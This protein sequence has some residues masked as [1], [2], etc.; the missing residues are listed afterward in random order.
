MTDLLF[1]WFG[2]DQTR[3]SI[4]GKVTRSKPVKQD[5]SLTVIIP[6]LVK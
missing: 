2:F 1:N 6:P 3:K 4:F 5:A